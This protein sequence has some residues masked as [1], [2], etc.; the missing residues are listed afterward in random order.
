VNRA[1]Q[2]LEAGASPADIAALPSLARL[3]RLGEEVG[4]NE[5]D[6]IDEL[7]RQVEAEFH[8]LEG[9]GGDR[10]E[11]DVSEAEGKG[12]HHGDAG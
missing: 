11:E 9:G 6:K 3:R 7:R 4:E 10:E 1:E 8:E 12:G 2:A 5:L